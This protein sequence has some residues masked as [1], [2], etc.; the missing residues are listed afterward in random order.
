ML[1]RSKWTFIIVMG[2][3]GLVF[4]GGITT[5]AFAQTDGSVILS[6]RIT[7]YL[8]GRIGTNNPQ[9]KFSCDQRIHSII[10][11]SELPLGNHEIAVQWFG[12]SDKLEHIQNFK[13][14]ATASTK[15]T[16]KPV[17][18]SS[19]I[20]FQSAGGLTSI[21]DPSAGLD[22]FIGDWRIVVL[23]NEENVALKRF[24]VIC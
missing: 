18:L 11:L 6:N 14:A 19:F 12:P 20:E 5:Q 4:N 7:H 17:Y 2:F 13:F 1:D 8:D 22:A 9:Q 23:D 3:V 16:G 15:A 24:S 10:E 21:F